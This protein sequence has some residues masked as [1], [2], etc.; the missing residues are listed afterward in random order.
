M[1]L[2]PV[3]PSAPPYCPAGDGSWQGEPAIMINTHPLDMTE[4]ML[5]AAQRRINEDED[6][7]RRYRAGTDY[8]ATNTKDLNF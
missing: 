6:F 1:E 5:R 8:T 7:A 4:P 2:R 3:N